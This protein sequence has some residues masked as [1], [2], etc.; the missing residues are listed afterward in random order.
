LI[1]GLRRRPLD[2]AVVAQ[3]RRLT[4]HEQRR[5]LPTS[6]VWTMHNLAEKRLRDLPETDPCY[7]MVKD[8]CR[9]AL[10]EYQ[11]RAMHDCL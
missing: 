1:K 7:L 11:T 9:G 6:L 5:N 3:V 10:W 4:E 2:P 8:I